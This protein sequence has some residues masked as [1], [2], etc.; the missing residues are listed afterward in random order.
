MIKVVTVNEYEEWGNPN[1]LDYFEYMLS[2]SPY[3]N[4]PT[5][6]KVVFIDQVPRFVG[7][8]RVI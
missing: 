7:Q 4:T 2:Y 8:G 6:V 3:E 1:E 5:G